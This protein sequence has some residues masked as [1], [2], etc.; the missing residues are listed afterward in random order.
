MII[1]SA[2]S[3]FFMRFRKL[4]GSI[5][6]YWWIRQKYLITHR[7]HAK[8]QHLKGQCR[9]MVFGS[10][11]PTASVMCKEDLSLKSKQFFVYV[12]NSLRLFTRIW[13]D[14]LGLFF[15]GVDICTW[16][17][18]RRFRRRTTHFL[19]QV[20]GYIPYSISKK[21]CNPPPLFHVKCISK[22]C[23]EAQNSGPVHY[24]LIRQGGHGH[25]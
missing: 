2:Y 18:F 1:C 8:V 16:T 17:Y 4:R 15:I 22:K 24:M 7:E 5:L 21:G 12:K 19:L 10:F 6:K 11:D 13:Q 25:L 20:A 23:N 3:S 14:Y 9:E